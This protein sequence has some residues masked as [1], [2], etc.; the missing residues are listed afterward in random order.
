MDYDRISDWDLSALMDLLPQER[1]GKALRY[2]QR[3]DRCA[4]VVS[5]AMLRLLLK[6]YCGITDPVF[7]SAESGKPFLLSDP[8]VHFNIS[9]AKGGCLAAVADVPVGVDVQD[10]VQFGWDAGASSEKNTH[11]VNG[12]S[13]ARRCCCPEELRFLETAA[14][15]GGAFTKMWVIKEAVSKMTGQGLS[16]G[17]ET[18]NSL[19]YERQG[20]VQTDKRGDLYMA[21]ALAGQGFPSQGI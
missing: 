9:H 17:F 1:Q 14:D 5:W 21:I 7:S 12:L 2:R 16:A 8:D 4:C 3:A 18:I 13:L 10:T 6:Q 20:L 19:Q 11:G 15:P